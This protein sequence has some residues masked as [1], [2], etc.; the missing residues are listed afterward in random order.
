MESPIVE[1]RRKAKNAEPKPRPWVSTMVEPRNPLSEVTAEAP[2]LRLRFVH[3]MGNGA[4]YNL[5]Q[6][7][8]LSI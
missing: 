3:G 8:V 6:Q 4:K 1:M 7:L 5:Q 2:K